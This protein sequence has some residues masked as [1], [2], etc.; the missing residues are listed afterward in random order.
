[1]STLAPYAL[2]ALLAPSEPFAALELESRITHLEVAA[3]GDLVAVAAE[4]GS[5]HVLDA[6]T[7]HE[8]RRIELGGPPLDL[9]ISDD[10][11]WIAVQTAPDTVTIWNST[12]KQPIR[13]LRH[14]AGALAFF[15][16][17]SELVLA[18]HAGKVRRVD[19]ASGRLGDS[20]AFQDARRIEAVELS[21]DGR[22]VAFA[23]DDG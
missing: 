6:R 5:L 9:A 14:E 17:T 23:L 2:A 19:A 18:D 12:A 10:G 1:M 15:A 21:R 20:R 16:E 22:V 11:N 3:R 8:R 13:E 4:C 7:L